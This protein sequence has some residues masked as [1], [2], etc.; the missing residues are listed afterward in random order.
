MKTSAAMRDFK[1]SVQSGDE[2]LTMLNKRQI[3][4]KKVVGFENKIAVLEAKKTNLSHSLSGLK[5]TV[6]T[7]QSGYF[8]TAVD[9]YENIFSVDKIENMSV[10]SFEEMCKLQ[11]EEY[12]KQNNLG[13]MFS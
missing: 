5:S 8:S 12:I 3:L 1:S 9:G 7:T 11:P 13:K 10:H 4:S 6:V 2:L